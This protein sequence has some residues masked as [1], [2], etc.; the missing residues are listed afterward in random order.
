MENPQ[1]GYL[2]TR[3]VVEWIPYRVVDYC[4]YA[5]GTEFRGKYR[6]RTALWTNTAWQPARP[7]CDPK[8]C[9]F[10]SDGRKHDGQVHEVRL[11]DRYAIP[12]P[13][14]EELCTWLEALLEA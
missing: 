1:T 11:H 8:T 12:A 5:R 2:K 6:K 14:P 10:C 9:H 7:L 4:Q 3:P 13:L